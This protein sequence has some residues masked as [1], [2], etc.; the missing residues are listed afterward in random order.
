MPGVLPPVAT[1]AP[2]GVA[3]ASTG[4]L[5]SRRGDVELTCDGSRDE[6]RTTLLGELDE[7]LS[8]RDERVDLRRLLVEVRDDAPLLVERREGMRSA[9]ATGW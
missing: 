1:A 5:P 9:A 4:E 2:H 3:T 6:R 8:L 7:A